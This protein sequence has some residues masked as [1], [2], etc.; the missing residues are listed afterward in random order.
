MSESR[1]LALRYIIGAPLS[2]V[3]PVIPT[4]LSQ[5]ASFN[6]DREPGHQP[7]W[8]LR[9]AFDNRAIGRLVLRGVAGEQSEL[10]A[11]P[12]GVNGH[13]TR[14]DDLIPALTTIVR[15]L[16][17]EG[18]SIKP[19]SGADSQDT[20]APVV[21]LVAPPT[22]FYQT[23]ATRLTP[24]VAQY[25]FALHRPPQEASDDPTIL[26]RDVA[27]AIMVIADLSTDCGRLAAEVAA[28]RERLLMPVAPQGTAVPARWK[29]QTLVYGE[30]QTE[31]LNALAERLASGAPTDNTPGVADW[32][33]RT[34]DG[35]ELIASE[36]GDSAGLGGAS[37][38]STEAIP[39]VVFSER[40]PEPPP[41][42]VL[43]AAPPDEARRAI[44]RTT[45]LDPRATPERRFHAAR[46]LAAYGD[47]ETAAAALGDVARA[48]TPLR[49]EALNLLGTLGEA[50][51]VALWAL[52]AGEENP[53]RSVAIA[54]Q[55]HKVGDTTTARLRLER[56][57]RHP[58]REVRLSALHALADLGAQAHREFAKLLHQA[59]DPRMQLEAARWLRLHHLELPQ[60]VET[61]TTLANQPDNVPLAIDAL[62]ELTAIRTPEAFESLVTLAHQ[63]RLSDMRLAAAQALSRRG[64]AEAARAALL[65]IATGQDE[66]AAS[67]A[68][69]ALLAF[70]QPTPSDTERLMLGAA[71]FSVRRRAAAH[72]A[73][74]DQPEEVQQ[75]AARA[76]LAL[77]RADQAVPTLTRLART[78]RDEAIRRWAVEQLAGLGSSAVAAML[79]VLDSTDDRTIGLRLAEAIL[80]VPPEPAIRRR[81]AG[82]LVAHES[83]IQA[84]EVLAGAGLDPNIPE[85]EAHAA[86]TDLARLAATQPSA[87]RAVGHLAR[88]APIASVRRRAL[89]FLLRHHIEELPLGTLVDLAVR[90]QSPA[91]L[92]PL[93]NYLPTVA[94]P[95]AQR[96]VEETL[97]RETPP[98]RRWRLLNLLTI[99]PRHVSVNALRQIAT[100]APEASFREVAAERL[101]AADQPEAGLA[102]LASLGQS[103]ASPEVRRRAIYRLQQAR[104]VDLLH[105]VA[106][107]SHYA[108]ARDLSAQLLREL[109]VPRND[110][111]WAE[112]WKRWVARLPL[113]WLDRWLARA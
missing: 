85:R 13:R 77:D 92:A 80:R 108:D 40:P 102:A 24:V 59:E 56:L 19:S 41:L 50:A 113:D 96:I 75:Q 57:A 88:Q 90:E 91:D 86:L 10:L 54:R 6:L 60:V 103:A 81:I 61:L 46:V 43:A 89:E 83:A 109:G 107:Q 78:A 42:T 47:R 111:G 98:V 76:L 23:L 68:T 70:V 79:E 28:A 65:A 101:L 55:L 52:D 15:R 14:P 71:L 74:P 30:D 21:L 26:E 73:S 7:S 11:A 62:H 16:R 36:A 45:A 29:R 100:R 38:A 37:V 94:S 48:A 12:A 58:D 95:V 1:S 99:L 66:D 8:K 4:L 31:F 35:A 17:D 53:E 32:A 39:T 25:G 84:A 97:H 63:A 34:D 82:W 93:L 33:A 49:D 5:E 3:L 112:R 20:S 110:L 106:A 27:A 22:R 104:A 18:F 105:A 69:E 72:L 51:R 67:S 9:R 87:V 44:Y 64:D 2:R